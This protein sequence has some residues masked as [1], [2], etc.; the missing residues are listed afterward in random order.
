M[1]GGKGKQRK[2]VDELADL[3]FIPK[4]MPKKRRKNG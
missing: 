1:A 4:N 2:M 3:G